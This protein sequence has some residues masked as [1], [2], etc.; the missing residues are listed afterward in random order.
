MLHVDPHRRL[1]AAQVLR[2]PWVM[3]R[4]QLP[5]YTLNRQDAPHL[6]KV[7]IHPSIHQSIHSLTNPSNHWPIHPL[8]R[9]SIFVMFSH[10]WI[11]LL[12]LSNPFCQK[13]WKLVFVFKRKLPC[14]TSGDLICI[15]LTECWV[16]C[17]VCVTSCPAGRHG[18]HLL[19]PEPERSPGPGAGGLLHSGP[20]EGDEEDHLHRSLTSSSSSSSCQLWPRSDRCRTSPPPPAVRSGWTD[21]WWTWEPLTPNR[22]TPRLCP[23]LHLTGFSWLLALASPINTNTN[24]WPRGPVDPWTRGPGLCFGQSALPRHSEATSGK[25]EYLL[26]SNGKP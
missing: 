2:H 8:T 4:D 16:N 1:T 7:T 13:T 6:V 14:I 11:I 20:A 22:S 18:R 17:S 10:F 26:T 5:K 12:I 24:P 19:G 21:Y 15:R 23:A 9:L 3:H 25:Q